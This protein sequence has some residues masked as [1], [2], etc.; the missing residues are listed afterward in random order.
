MDDSSVNTESLLIALLDADDVAG[1]DGFETDTDDAELDH[2]FGLETD[3]VGRIMTDTL[4]FGEGYRIRF[5]RHIT[6]RNRT[7]EFD[8]TGDTAI[9]LVTYAI[10]GEL[11]VKAFD[12]TDHTQIDSIS[13]SK[14]FTSSFVRKV[15]FVQYEND[16][17]PDGYVWRQLHEAQPA[18]RSNPQSGK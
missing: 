11:F 18:D 16:S 14:E 3:G 7:V 15:R 9:G 12:T 17:N 13:F 10:T 8:I 5:G 2:E 6:A 1:V 4:A